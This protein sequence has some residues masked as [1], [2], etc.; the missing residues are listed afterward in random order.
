MSRLTCVQSDRTLYT[1]LYALYTTLYTLLCTMHNVVLYI[2][3]HH[4]ASLAINTSPPGTAL[5]S[6]SAGVTGSV[7]EGG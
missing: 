2:Q 7:F 1:T 5:M 3:E 4:C 6:S